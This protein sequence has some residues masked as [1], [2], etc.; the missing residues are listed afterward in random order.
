MQRP[1][2]IVVFGILCLVMGAVS[3]FKNLIEA[4]VALAGPGVMEQA[5][6]MH[7]QWG[8][9]EEVVDSSRA[10]AE[11]LRTTG[12]RALLGVESLVTALMAAVVIVA[13]VGLLLGR[14]W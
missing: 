4:G 6:E 3:G 13:G 8:M 2:R 11:A 1:T 10:Q 7:E 14:L 5:A 12:Y 9:S